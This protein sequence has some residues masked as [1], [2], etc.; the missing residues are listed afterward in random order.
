MGKISRNSGNLIMCIGEIVIGVLLLIDPTG[1]TSGIIILLGVLLA[2]AGIKSVVGYF[3]TDPE[4][5]AQQSALAKGLFLAG[6]GL[7]CIFR[8]DWFIAAFPL[9][10]V[11]Y[12]VLIL[13]SGI[14]KVQW[15]VD[16]FRLKQPYWYVTLIGAV[17]SLA[18]GAIVLVNPFA[19]TAALWVFI[20]VSLIVEAVA[21]ILSFFLGRR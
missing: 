2:A 5:A 16:L 7:F 10:T 13:L 1:F 9:L 6:A 15:A 21:D 14:S 12:G 11:F 3:R 20:A 8:S 19:S 4:A 17:L 18:F